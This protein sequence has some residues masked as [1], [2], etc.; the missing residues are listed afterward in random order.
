MQIRRLQTGV[1]ALS[2]LLLGTLGIVALRQVAHARRLRRMALT[3]E[4]TR[5]PNRRHILALAE[6]EMRLARRRHRPLCLMALDV[7]HFK[8]INDRVG[9]DAG[10]R[11]LQRVAQACAQAVQRDGHV[12][13]VGGE[14]FLILLPAA[15]ANA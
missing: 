7:D 12:G 9:H 1:I 11:V 13:R 8:R 3:D 5:L 4:L 14:E 6:E 2:V 15:D 10:D